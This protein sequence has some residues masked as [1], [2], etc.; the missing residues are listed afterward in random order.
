[1]ALF[2][3][4]RAGNPVR[5]VMRLPRMTGIRMAVIFRHYD[6]PGRGVLGQRLANTCRMRGLS[7]LVAGDPSLAMRLRADGVHLPQWQTYR[8]R[9]LKNDHPGWI[10][11]A[12]CHDAPSLARAAAADCA[13]LS[14][15]F[16]TASHEGTL[17]L[18]PLRAH[19][20][21]AAARLPVLALGGI[22]QHTAG[23]IKPGLFAG[24]GAIDGFEAD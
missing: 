19:A 24:F 9:G 12:A 21:A 3:D 16:V 4:E 7:F 23:K 15:V 1:M 8:I 17:P 20:M 18:G 13:F 10:V 5:I 6:T 14:P 22:N 11:S 2:T